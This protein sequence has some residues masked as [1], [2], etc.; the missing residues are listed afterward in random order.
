MQ[1][2]VIVFVSGLVYEYEQTVGA[3]HRMHTDSGGVV[4]ICDVGMVLIGQSMNRSWAVRLSRMD[5]LHLPRRAFDAL[6]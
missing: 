5:T 2:G 1:A 3:A 6:R 4:S